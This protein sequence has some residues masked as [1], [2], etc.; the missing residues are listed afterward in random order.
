MIPRPAPGVIA[1]F[2]ALMLAPLTPLPTAAQEVT[3][4]TPNV[5]PEDAREV[6]PDAAPD[7]TP[8]VAGASAPES[9]PGLAECTVRDSTGMITLVICP[10]GLDAA[11]LQLAGQAACDGREPCLAW[12]WDD[13]EVVPAEAPPTSEELGGEALAAAR[14]VWVQDDRQLISMEQP[15]IGI[16]VEAQDEDLDEDFSDTLG[17]GD[18]LLPPLD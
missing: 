13:P 5:P 18:P 14:A 1:L 10:P 4:D 8:D 11:D 3:Q 6:T 9:V 15:Y 16:G 12:I 2:A 17:P 7:A